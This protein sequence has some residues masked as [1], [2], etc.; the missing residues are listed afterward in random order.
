MANYNLSTRAQYDLVG[1]Y[2]YGIKYFGQTPATQYLCELENFLIELASRPE[3]AKDASS[4]SNFLKFY[5]FKSHVIFYMF[6]NDNEIYIVR[7]LGKRM[8]FVEHL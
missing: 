8:N 5:S 4:I 3:L 2:K 1:I 6:D 7:V